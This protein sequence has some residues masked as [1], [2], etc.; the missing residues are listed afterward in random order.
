MF[1]A[2]AIFYLPMTRPRKKT[3][4]LYERGG[5]RSRGVNG[6]GNASYK[7]V[8]IHFRWLP[9]ILIHASRRFVLLT[10]RK[11][12]SYEQKLDSPDDLIVLISY[13]VSFFIELSYSRARTIRFSLIRK[14][15]SERRGCRID[16]YLIHIRRKPA[17]DYNID[18]I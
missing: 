17:S 12:P 11:R 13:G 2:R 5:K 18:M 1:C 14:E 6:E 8:V 15:I 10:W 3:R 9:L 16:L 4:R 7:W